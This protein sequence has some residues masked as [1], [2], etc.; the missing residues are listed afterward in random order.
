MGRRLSSSSGRGGPALSRVQ[1]DL[2]PFAAAAK[3]ALASLSTTLKVGTK[4]LQDVTPLVTTVLKYTQALLPSTE[5]FATLASNLQQ[6][7][8]VENFLSVTYYIT[9]AL[10]RFDGISHLLSI[11]LIGPNNGLCGSFATKPVAGCSAHYGSQP[12]FTP[13]KASADAPRRAPEARACAGT[14]R[15]I[16][17]GAPQRTSSPRGGSAGPT[18]LNSKPASASAGPASGAAPQPSSV[19]PSSGTSASATPSA[20]TPSSGTTSTGGSE[21]TQSASQSLQSLVQY[22]LK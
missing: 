7:G 21:G 8:F 15:C 17:R 12:A 13:V 2:V 22:L 19:T 1:H 14:V 20:G 16:G 4:A 9:A 6:H 18:S 10:A 5:L 11:L 3:P